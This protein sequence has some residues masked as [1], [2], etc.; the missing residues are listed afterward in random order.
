M[1]KRTGSERRKKLRTLRIRLKKLFPSLA[2]T[3]F[4]IV[5][6]YNGRYNC[7]SWAI[8]NTSQRLS[9]QKRPGN[10]WHRLV[11]PFTDLDSFV[12]V[13]ELLGGFELCKN[14]KFVVGYEKIAFYL[15]PDNRPR[16]AARQLDSKTW[17]SKI[18]GGCLIHHKGL[19]CLNG[20]EYGKAEVFMKRRIQ[21]E[22]NSG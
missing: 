9:P 5:S 7:Y 4:R 19:S 1:R 18:G 17:S 16:H 6:L 10:L 11:N 14:A 3:R 22:G 2:S 15:G 8:G 13:F 12:R 20:S 21:R